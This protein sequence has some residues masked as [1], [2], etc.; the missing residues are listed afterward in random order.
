MWAA[1]SSPLIV[2]VA[3]GGRFSRLLRVGSPPTRNKRFRP[4][5]S[6]STAVESASLALLAAVLAGR[7][8]SCSWKGFHEHPTNSA[9]QCRERKCRICTS[10]RGIG[11]PNWSA[12]TK[13][14]YGS[15]RERPEPSHTYLTYDVYESVR[16]L[17]TDSYT[18]VM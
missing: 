11:R 16:T 9:G 12:N 15:V 2:V 10:D 6:A 18:S 5:R 17:R 4:A 1:E 14:M 7:I 8:R 13:G 3:V